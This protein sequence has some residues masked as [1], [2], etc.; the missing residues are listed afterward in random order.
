[1]KPKSLLIILL[2]GSI[3]FSAYTLTLPWIQI[4]PGLSAVFNYGNSVNDMAADGLSFLTGLL[5]DALG[6]RG[7]SETADSLKDFRKALKDEKELVDILS[8]KE[9]RPYDF[10]RVMT[11]MGRYYPDEDGKLLFT[12][13]GYGFYLIIALGFIAFA[14][15]I[16][17]KFSWAALFAAGL[18]IYLSAVYT[19][20]N[21]VNDSFDALLL[22]TADSWNLALISAGMVF[23]F[24]VC[25]AFLP[26]RARASSGWTWKKDRADAGR[27]QKGRCTAPDPDAEENDPYKNIWTYTVPDPDQMQE[28]ELHTGTAPEKRGKKK[29]RR[30]IVMIIAV[31]LLVLD[32]AAAAALISRKKKTDTISIDLSSYIQVEVSGYEGYGKAQ[33]TFD[34]NTLYEDLN[35]R[36]EERAEINSSETKEKDA[37]QDARAVLEDLNVTLSKTDHL[38]NGDTFSLEI[39]PGEGTLEILEGY[40]ILLD[41]EKVQKEY[42]VS[43]LEVVRS[44]D[45]FEDLYYFFEGAEPFGEAYAYYEGNYGDI[46]YAEVTP[47]DG[48]R[49]GD[50]VTITVTSDY[51]EEGL[52]EYFGIELTKT[53]MTA[54]VSGLMGYPA[55]VWDLSEQSIEKVMEEAESIAITKISDEYESEEQMAGLAPLGQILASSDADNAQIHNHLFC[56]FRVSYASTSGDSRDYIY[57]VGFRD[58]MTDPK[59]GDLMFTTDSYLTPQKPDFIADTLNMDLNLSEFVMIRLL[60]PRILSGFNTIQ[61]FYSRYVSPL[62]DTCSI[63]VRGSDLEELR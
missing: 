55:S 29:R 61:S 11:T 7:D 12:A 23:F 56:L 53:Q 8:G 33:G 47:S 43:D 39:R 63:T 13:L 16:A 22:E 45:P 26:T 1:M 46:L 10:S 17:E 14:A 9:C 20:V 19:A 15:V 32:I 28:E 4:H 21:T 44:Y 3:L 24:Y 38:S 57:F 36:M 62:E 35:A 54:G 42:T 2:A 25:A 41:T 31:V 48:L 52:K 5:G 40:H 59:T 49:N 6:D 34:R 27:E 18:G 58:V 50:T 37:S 30:D 51:D 60:P